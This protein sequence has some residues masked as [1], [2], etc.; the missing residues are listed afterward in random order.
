VIE[1][2]KKLGNKQRAGGQERRD[3]VTAWNLRN[4]FVL[5][6]ALALL[7]LVAFAVVVIVS[8]RSGGGDGAYVG[9]DLH[10]LAVDPTN[11]DR[12]MVGGHEGAAISPDGGESWRQ[13]AD[14]SGADPMGW[15]INP[16]D[17]QRMYAGGHPGFFRSEDGGE[18]WSMDNS[19][20]PG[21]DV[22]GLGMDPQN[23]DT[24]YAFIA[25][26]GIFRRRELGTR[27]RRG[28]RDG[29]DPR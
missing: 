13:I 17:P 19:G 22:H 23:P 24:L 16:T 4:A 27:Q 18:S 3:P 15:V 5:A 21:T 26:G 8:A 29:F 25:G 12:V 14:L 11:P 6:G 7:V 2:T 1:K 28:G 9:G 20:L 10:A